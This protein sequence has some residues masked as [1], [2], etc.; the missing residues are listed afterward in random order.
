MDIRQKKGFTLIE[1]LVVI[2]IIALLLAILMPALGKVKEK[3]RTVVCRANLK[4]W[5]LVFGL[6]VQDNDGR[7]YR[8]WKGAHGHE[9][10]KCTM[11]Y[12]ENPKIRFC[13]SAKKLGTST[14]PQANDEAWGPF[15]A[16]V[17]YP[18]YVDVAGSYGIND[19]VGDTEEGVQY[20]GK[21]MYWEHPTVK[22]S[23]NAPLFIDSIWAGG[24]PLHTDTPP[25]SDTGSSGP[26]QMGRYCFDRHRGT[27]NV[28]FV[29]FSVRAVDLKELW[30][31]KWH[32]NFDTSFINSRT[33]W[34]DWM[35]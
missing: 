8:A 20:G 26:E 16:N 32:R 21:G 18:Y 25:D 11:P 27:I 24:F 33:E 17:K 14:W 9:W 7:Y 10:I 12:Y 22:G 23:S 31:L 2:S 30:Q 13:P 6:Y 35:R 15:D 3:A 4:Q 29:D 5:G 34:P 1:L 19:W 28:V